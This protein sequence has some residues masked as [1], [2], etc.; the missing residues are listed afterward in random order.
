MRTRLIVIML[1]ASIAQTETPAAFAV[2]QNWTIFGQVR[3]RL[4]VRNGYRTLPRDD[5]DDG[6]LFISQRSRLGIGYSSDPRLSFTVIVQDIRTWGDERN[7]TSDY[8]ADN[9]DLFRGFIDL[10][11]DS[12]W[13]LRIGRQGISYDEER[14]LGEGDW[15]Q[16]GRS[17]DAIRV[18]WNNGRYA[19][20]LGWA[21]HEQGEP[22]RHSP[23]TNVTNY[24][25]LAFVWL[26]S[27]SQSGS[28]SLL[29]VYDDHELFGS[30]SIPGIPTRRWTVGGYF[31]R[32]SG[33]THGRAELYWQ[34]GT[35]QTS[36]AEADISAYMFGL[37]V[38]RD[39]GK[40]NA[41]LWY[42]YLSG[43]DRPLD[44]EMKVFDPPYSTGHRFYGW[45]DYFLN[46]PVD[47]YGHG[48]QDIALKIKTPLNGASILA[49]HLHYFLL[50]EPYETFD[51]DAK[52]A[53]GFEADLMATIPLMKN[54][55][56]QA[57]YSFVNPTEFAKSLTGGDSPGHWFWTALDVSVK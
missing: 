40:T 10:K 50:A 3:P 57:G 56:L 49:I 12:L 1:L 51:G 15:S 29:A 34:T 14:V 38:D 7:T 23:Y 11:P 19:A 26:Q 24:Q 53:L 41:M 48:L 35:R 17:H 5:A 36:F 21:H 9:F 25:D 46:I 20:H 2:D 31:E 32:R 8:T 28:V 54:A 4:E 37:E 18:M 27:R 33:E 47:T 45:A 52:S 22:V 42:D 6:V 44:D 16:Q 30:V 55:R 39:F 43:D 13:S